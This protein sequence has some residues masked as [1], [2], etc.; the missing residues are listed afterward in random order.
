MSV[1]WSNGLASRQTEGK[2]RRGGNG[3]SGDILCL[4]T[5]G[6]RREEIELPAFSSGFYLAA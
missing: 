4:V 3:E 5:Q 2:K 1:L 6:E